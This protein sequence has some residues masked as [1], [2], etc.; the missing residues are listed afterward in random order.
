MF[1]AIFGRLCSCVMA[2]PTS[3]WPGAGA[4]LVP[5]PVMATRLSCPPVPSDQ[6]QFVFGL[7]SAMKSSPPASLAMA[8]A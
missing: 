6:G 1:P 2:T 7:A 3:A 8:A 5:S 4:S